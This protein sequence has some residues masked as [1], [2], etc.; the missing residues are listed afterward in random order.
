MPR[1]V[2][3]ATPAAP[4][5]VHL[6]TKWGSENKTLKLQPD[7]T[8]QFQTPRIPWSQQLWFGFIPVPN[9]RDHKNPFLFVYD[10]TNEITVL[11]PQKVWDLPKDEDGKGILKLEK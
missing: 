10:G 8:Y 7:G 2:V 4:S 5:S 9:S 3:L 1:D 6:Q 11:S